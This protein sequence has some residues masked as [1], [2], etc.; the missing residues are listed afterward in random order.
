MHIGLFEPTVMMFGLQGAP[1]TFSRMIAVDIAP[2]YHEFPP[3]HFKHYINDCLITTADD[4]LALH[5]CMNHQL[6]DIFKE[7]LY[8]L[9]PLKCEF[10]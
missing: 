10:K 1:G 6:L 8:F 9:K 2:M 5:C 3:N 7:H 4:E